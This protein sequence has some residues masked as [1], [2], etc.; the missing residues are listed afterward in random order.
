[1]K[2]LNIFIALLGLLSFAAGASGLNKLP[3]DADV[4]IGTLPNGLTYYIRQNATPANCADFFIAQR[5]GSVNEEENQRGL[6]HFLEH[7]CFNGTR[8]FPGNSLI[9]YLESIG[10]KFGANLNAYTSTDETV[11]NI[12]DVPTTRQ[13]SLDSCLLILRD[14][15]HDLTLADADIDAERGVIKGEWRQRQGTANNR[16]LEK[17]APVVYGNSIYGRRMPIGLMS[18][19]ENFPYDALRDY[20]KRWYYPENQCVIVVGDVN[21]DVIEAKIK[22]LWADVERPSFNVTPEKAVVPDNDK[23]IATVQSDPEQVT[24]VVQIFIKHDN[25]PDSDVNTINELRRE[26][27][28][29]LVVDMLAERLTDLETSTGTLMSNVGIGDRQFLLSRSRDALMVRAATTTGREAECVNALAAELRRAALYGFTDTEIQRAKLDE[30]ARLDRQFTGRSKTTNTQYARVYVRHYLDGGALPSQEQYYK[31]MKGV[32]GQVGLPE[33]NDYINSVVRPDCA[34]VV[35]I[36]YLPGNNEVELTDAALADA[37]ASVDE[38]ALVPYTV[39]DLGKPLLA[40][41]PVAGSIVAEEADSLFGSTVWTLSNGIR[42]HLKKTSYSPD[43]VLVAGYS[44]GGFSVG[45]NPELAPEYHLV[46][47]VLAAGAYGGHTATDLRRITAGKSVRVDVSIDNMEERILASTTASDMETAMQL[48]YLKATQPDRDDQAFSSII[49]NH[50][51]KLSSQNSNPTF[52]MADSIHY[53]VYDRHPL[54]AKLSKE[55]LD[56]VSYDRIIDMHRDRFGDMTDFDFYVIGDFDTDSL[57]SLAERYIASLPAAGRRE[58]ACDIGYHYIK[59]RE[60]MRFTTPMETPQTIA[61]TFYNYPCE[62]NLPNVI[63]GHAFGSLMQSALLRDLREERGWTY[64]IKAHGG[65]GAGMNGD[66]PSNFIMP[67]YIRV[68]PENADSTFAIVADTAESLADT[69]NI[70]DDDLLKVKQYM[71]KSYAQNVE[72]NSYWLTVLHMYD[73]FGRDMH[74]GYTELVES[75]TPAAIAGFAKE[76][77]LPANR[78]QL[79]MSPAE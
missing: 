11:Y 72:N 64:S 51:M 13:S 16:M 9:S 4:R 58:K 61:Y 7:M 46:N 43:Q 67:V 57:R 71:L 37:Y 19:V 39:H 69:A 33:V 20:Y 59:G 22:E 5:V 8:H 66:D 30:R 38:S 47:D 76:I 25:L 12:C 56:K 41:M 77:I 60:R 48:I 50:R 34:N 79:S 21:P 2:R 54:G 52:T 18:V 14:W 1:M 55:D 40:Q 17:A 6:A 3:V 28:R 78:A 73:K 62:Y 32:L 23:I 27:A 31:M 53:Y 10:V 24:P 75:L 26:L 63:K 29:D 70:S 36:A 15:S 35:L 65:V 42:I 68:A 44:P 45:Y 74:N 49:E